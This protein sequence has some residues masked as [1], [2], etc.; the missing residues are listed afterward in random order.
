MPRALLSKEAAALARERAA[1]GDKAALELVRKHEAAKATARANRVKNEKPGTKRGRPFGSRTL[2][3][4]KAAKVARTAIQNAERSAELRAA[5]V[6]AEKKLQELLDGRAPH[7]FTDEE[8]DAEVEEILLKHEPLLS[9]IKEAG[10]LIYVS[11]LLE[12][13]HQ[14]RSACCAA[15]PLDSLTV[16][17]AV[18]IAAHNDVR[19]D[20]EPYNSVRVSHGGRK[21][22]LVRV[23]VE[24][25][26][27][28]SE[29]QQKEAQLSEN[30][31]KRA[32][33]Q[34]KPLFDG[35]HWLNTQLIEKKLHIRLAAMFPE[36]RC[37]K[38]NGGGNLSTYSTGGGVSLLW[39][40]AVTWIARD[41][42]VQRTKPARS[43][44]NEIDDDSFE[45]ENEID[46][47]DSGDD[48]SDPHT[49]AAAAA[50]P[51]QPKKQKQRT[52]TSFFAPKPTPFSFAAV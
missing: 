11:A 42:T 31:L 7:I 26:E 20:V 35:E 8:G 22:T 29:E 13:L 32:G 19:A 9:K 49:A 15:T 52:L 38:K 41:I 36:Q 39:G 47:C 23:T 25:Y 14:T 51:P 1:G 6:R 34:H 37:W 40:P 10:D 44:E 16:H 18:Q 4:V 43:D 17:C 46:P 33:Y 27:E 5:T 24:P 45:N 50:A 3:E 30:D 2:A 28:L 12:L 48:S 21:P